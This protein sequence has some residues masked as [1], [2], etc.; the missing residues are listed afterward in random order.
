LM[1]APNSIGQQCEN[2]H[3]HVAFSSH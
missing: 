3:F 1:I 2:F